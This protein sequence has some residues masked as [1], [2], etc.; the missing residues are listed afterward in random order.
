MTK[1]DALRIAIGVLK[2]NQANWQGKDAA[3]KACEEALAQVEQ[4]PVAWMSLMKE[5]R[6]NC[7]ASIVEDGI[8]AMRKEYR[9]DLERRLTDFINTNPKEWQDLTDE[10]ID[11]AY[12]ESLKSFRRHQMR[13]R[14]QQ[15]TASDNPNWHFALAIL[16]AAKEKNT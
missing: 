8:S 13:I 11:E 4:K 1:D 9:V 3:I 14:G 16:K 15:I 12:D 7:K 2:F 5:A 10:E 6:D